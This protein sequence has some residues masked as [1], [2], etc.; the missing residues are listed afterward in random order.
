MA[1]YTGA[2]TYRP[3]PSNTI[4][5]GSA[6]SSPRYPPSPPTSLRC[7]R[8][9]SS[10]G[11]EGDHGRGRSVAP[12]EPAPNP[13]NPDN[14]DQTAGVTFLGQFIDHDMTFD[15]TSSL[16]RQVDPEAVSNFRV[17]ALELD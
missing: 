9:C 16:E 3:D 14:P 8:A 15:P 7:G 11:R 6:G 1:S 10:S 12:G 4:G 17:P 5:E 2:T 13:K